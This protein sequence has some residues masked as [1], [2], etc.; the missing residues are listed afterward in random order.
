MK[1]LLP[2]L[3]LLLA[4]AA[5][6]DDKVAVVPWTQ[7]MKLAD[8]NH[9]GTVSMNEVEKFPHQKEYVGFQAFMADHFLDL[10]TNGDGRVSDNEFRIGLLKLGIG[11]NE[12]SNGFT[13]GFRFMPHH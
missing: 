4:G 10:D 7:V 9:D 8:T 3:A 11:E 2:W 5:C 12:V 6:A 1:Y 13:H